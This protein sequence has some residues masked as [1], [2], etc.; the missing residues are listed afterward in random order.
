MEIQASVCLG[1]RRE[2][3]CMHKLNETTPQ[4]TLGTQESN[5]VALVG[6]NTTQSQSKQHPPCL[7][8]QC[9]GSI[10]IRMAGNTAPLSS[11][12][13][14]SY[15]STESERAP[16]PGHTGQHLQGATSLG[17]MEKH[18]LNDSK[19]NTRQPA[20]QYRAAGLRVPARHLPR[21]PRN[22]G[23]KFCRELRFCIVQV[24]A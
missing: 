5:S 6:K 16:I 18:S 24:Q 22:T 20:A 3:G 2:E 15:E 7:Y 17:V 1:C 19:S 11:L 4:G 8:M 23:R 9:R 14:C 13:I 10:P 12:R 21:P